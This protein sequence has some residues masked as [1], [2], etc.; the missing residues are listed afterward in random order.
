MVACDYRTPSGVL[1]RIVGAKNLLSIG[2]LGNAA[3]Y[4]L[5]P[6]AVVR[7][8]YPTAALLVAKGLCQSCLESTRK[9]TRNPPVACDF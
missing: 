2:L 3:S 6:I 1:C 8:V 9:Y 4:L 7:G 5:L